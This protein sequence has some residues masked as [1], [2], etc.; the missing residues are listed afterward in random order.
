MWDRLQHLDVC[1][2]TRLADCLRDLQRDVLRMCGCERAA[3]LAEACRLLSVELDALKL[4]LEQLLNRARD[5][6]SSGCGANDATLVLKTHPKH[7]LHTRLYV[8]YCNRAFDVVCS[9]HQSTR[10]KLLV[11]FSVT[12]KFADSSKTESAT[13][14]TSCFSSELCRAH[15]VRSPIGATGSEG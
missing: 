4:R 9:V 8:Q 1:E 6:L 3:F 12:S 5:L 11:R 14:R 2:R 10:T 13:T 7:Y 15:A